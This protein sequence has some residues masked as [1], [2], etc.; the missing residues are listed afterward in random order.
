MI[1]VIF[2]I[3]FS[4]SA[5]IILFVAIGEFTYR[6]AQKQNYDHDLASEHELDRR[7]VTRGT[8]NNQDF[9]I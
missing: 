8:I 9:E 4:L 3:A 7:A 6:L 1:E 5:A 2:I